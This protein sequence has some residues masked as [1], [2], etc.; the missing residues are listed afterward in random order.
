MRGRR[1]DRSSSGMPDPDGS[2][3]K[4]D[5]VDP[6]IRYD[7]NH[8]WYDNYDKE[9]YNQTLS[10]T[11]DVGAELQF[12]FFGAQVIVVGASIAPPGP[13]SD[14][15]R[16]AI[17][18]YEL[19]EDPN[20]FYGYACSMANATAVTF[21]DS[22]PLPSGRHTLKVMVA[23]VTV[24]TPFFL[25]YIAVAQANASASETLTPVAPVES[26]SVTA[27]GEVASSTASSQQ[28][29]GSAAGENIAELD[30]RRLAAIVGGII[31]GL[32]VLAVLGVVA[33][34]LCLRRR[35]RGSKGYRY[36]GFSSSAMIY[37]GRDKRR[38]KRESD[39][40]AAQIEP[41]LLPA[42]DDVFADGPPSASMH[43]APGNG[44]SSDYTSPPPHGPHLLA[45]P[46]S[47]AISKSAL[48]TE[49]GPIPRVSI[50]SE[51]VLTVVNGLVG[52]TNSP[53]LNKA[54]EASLNARTDYGARSVQYHLDSGVRFDTDSVASMPAS[55]SVSVPMHPHATPQPPGPPNLTAKN[56]DA[57]AAAEL[58]D[59]DRGDTSPLGEVPPGY[60]VS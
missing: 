17:S 37:D 60:T 56:T 53:A 24:E 23:A 39:I 49:L 5:D 21:F 7:V 2:F 26:H 51:R 30:P 48:P 25:D 28:Q 45:S 46:P 35:R 14:T 20:K 12:D 44:T 9:T 40:R 27:S 42:P 13:F 59:Q 41:F 6:S 50:S 19:D 32:G 54:E 31:G 10:S 38:A 16:G 29:G 33:W 8:T 52:P 3:V 57:G 55:V 11:M 58:A 43:S 1:L 36:S 34:T 4:F 47:S 15:A 22:G 18:Y